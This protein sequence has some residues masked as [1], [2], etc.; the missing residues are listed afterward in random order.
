MIDR[1]LAKTQRSGSSASRRHL[2][3]VTAGTARGLQQRRGS[4]HAGRDDR[5]RPP[6]PP[7]TFVIDVGAQEQLTQVRRTAT[8]FDMTE[9]EAILNKTPITDAVI[10]HW[11]EK[12]GER[13]TIV[14]C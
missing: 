14:F 3:A 11:R 5:L 4:N 2:P 7:R 10:R 12:A 9:V 6:R 8:D 13:K 1:C